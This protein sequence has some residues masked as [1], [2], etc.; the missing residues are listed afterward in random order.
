MQF[1]FMIMIG[2]TFMIKT[3][4]YFILI[5]MGISLIFSCTSMALNLG[6][7][8]MK[9]SEIK[10]K[11]EIDNKEVSQK[12][13]QAFIDSLLPSKIAYFCERE[14]EPGSGTTGYKLKDKSDNTYQV[15]EFSSKAA[16]TFSVSRFENAQT[17][18]KV[19][20]DSYF[21]NA[22][23]VFSVLIKDIHPTF[24]I[25]EMLVGNNKWN[26]SGQL[27]N[28]YKGNLTNKLGES[29]SSEIL[30]YDGPVLSRPAGFW[31]NTH[32]NKDESWLFFSSAELK[33]ASLNEILKAN[34]GYVINMNLA[35]AYL[36][37]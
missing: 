4:N 1:L 18:T 20:F 8:K 13:Y 30:I 9:A 27:V 12:T 23:T 10:I 5:P 15:L 22:K 26:L 6:S 31:V 29:F 2:H 3:L 32:P 14:N 37:K 35:G 7:E 24:P 28:L 16:K 17:F 19:E 36:R 33:K 25:D 21:A 11:Y 34:S